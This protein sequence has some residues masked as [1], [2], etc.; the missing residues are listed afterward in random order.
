MTSQT[1][2]TPLT[3]SRRQGQ[4][5]DHADIVAQGVGRSNGE[6][7]AAKKVAPAEVITYIVLESQNLFEN[8]LRSQLFLYFMDTNPWP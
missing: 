6:I 5:V 8:I 7:P 1:Q 3:D 4:P 2:Q